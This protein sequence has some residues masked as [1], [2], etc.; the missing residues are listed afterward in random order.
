M[1]N[2]ENKPLSQNT[3]LQANYEV[4]ARDLRCPLPLLKMKQALNQAKPGEVV[5]VKVTDP[6]SERD[7]KAYIAMTDHELQIETAGNLYLY[8]IIKK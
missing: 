7:F 6:A 2:P 8:W 4:D 5:F 1:L 3:T